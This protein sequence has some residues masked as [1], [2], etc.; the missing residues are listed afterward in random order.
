MVLPLE[1]DRHSFS[2]SYLAFLRFRWTF[3]TGDFVHFSVKVWGIVVFRIWTNI[4][5]GLQPISRSIQVL[6]VDQIWCLWDC[7]RLFSALWW[8]YFGWVSIIGSVHFLTPDAAVSVRHSYRQGS[9]KQLVIA[10][11]ILHCSKCIPNQQQHLQTNRITK[12]DQSGY[13]VFIFLAA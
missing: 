8:C 1:L 6:T 5:Y 10:L 7:V 11:K 2:S 4:A 12:L 3:T 13:V 9:C